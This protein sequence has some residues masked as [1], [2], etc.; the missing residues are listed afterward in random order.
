MP[1]VPRHAKLLA[2]GGYSDTYYDAYAEY[3]DFLGLVTRKHLRND[4]D[5][6]REGFVPVTSLFEYQAES[7]EHPDIWAAIATVWANRGTYA[8]IDLLLT[9]M[10]AALTTA[11]YTG[12][13]GIPL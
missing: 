9:A 1:P 12:P 10:N 5:I 7:E 13:G 2:Q 8:T 4:R 3:Q 11:G 6:L